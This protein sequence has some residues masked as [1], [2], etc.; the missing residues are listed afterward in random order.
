[1]TTAITPGII[2]E[3]VR[4]LVER[5]DPLRVI[6]F[7]ACA[8][9]EIGPDSDVDLFVIMP[10]GTDTRQ[11]AVRMLN[12]LADAGVPKDVLVGTPDTLAR[13]GDAPG[14]IYR[15]VLKEGKSLY[16]RST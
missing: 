4:R 12:A 5:F 8:R 13:L 7:G 10:D 9:D 16:E 1:M 15:T 14:L 2:D 6:L 11:A 3:M